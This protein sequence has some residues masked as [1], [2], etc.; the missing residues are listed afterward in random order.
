MKTNLLK[1]LFLTALMTIPVVVFGQTTTYEVTAP[2]EDGYVSNPDSITDNNPYLWGY[3]KLGKSAVDGS[4]HLTSCIIPF[5]LPERPAGKKVVS[6]KL[7]VYVS[8]GREWLNSNVDLYGLP[9]K[10]DV[11]NGGTGRQIFATDY[12]SGPFV[13]DHGTDVAI[14]DDYFTK[15]VELGNLDDPRW[16]ETSIDGNAALLKY[17]N[18]QYDAGAEAGD[19]VFLRLSIDNADMT[20]AQYFKIEGGDSAT[21][22][23]LTLEIE[24]SGSETPVWDHEITAPTEDG[25]VSNPDSITDNNPYL[26]GYMKLG[27]SAVDGSAHLTAC[28]IPFQLPER[29]EGELVT[30][31]SLKV[32]V[33]YGRQWLNSNVDLYGLPYQKSIDNGGT[34][35]QIFAT[36]F[37]AGPFVTDHGTDVAIE[38][39]YF[40]KNVKLGELDSAR[41]EETSI[42]G[43]AALVKYINDQYDAGAVAGDWVFLRLSIDNVDMTGS[44][45]F[46]IEGG[47][48]STPA[49]LS[50]NISGSTK[51][52]RTEIKS[53]NV[54]PNP[55]TDGHF[56]ISSSGLSENATL[57]IYSLTG[58]VVYNKLMKSNYGRTDITVNL[59]RGLY[60][61]KIAD[62]NAIKTAKLRIQ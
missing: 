38:D 52:N 53:F 27:K 6:A 29:P 45:Y 22:S 32:Y 28:I 9:F 4:A 5:Q 15:N 44:Q 41:W 3:M 17:I 42:T 23:T 1:S 11:D 46:K 33:S 7:K 37:Y 8:Y 13:T 59:P 58:E 60:L 39:D 47:D 51:I 2:T 26:W 54:Y 25:Y 16:E 62:G 34:G 57:T 14:E 24:D 31:A 40:T 21:P 56:M 35:R 43:N 55:V 49:T 48:S 20:G 61:I 18:D 12:Y 10:K 19:W 36:D 30:E 50:M